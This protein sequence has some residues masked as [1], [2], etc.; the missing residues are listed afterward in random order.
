MFLL[1]RLLDC[2][3]ITDAAEDRVI[4]IGQVTKNHNGIVPSII[5]T[6]ENP[7]VFRRLEPD[8]FT[9][10]SNLFVDWFPI[11]YDARFRAQICHNEPP[12]FTIAAVHPTEGVVGLVIYRYESS[13][14]VEVCRILFL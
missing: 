2:G 10:V 9:V 4:D 12:Y 6:D 8:D 1:G 11:H 13:G 14:S 7:I 3:F 5:M